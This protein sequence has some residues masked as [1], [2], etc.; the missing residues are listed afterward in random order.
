MHIPV[1]RSWRT[2][3]QKMKKTLLL[4]VAAGLLASC[5]K[6]HP[7]PKWEDEFGICLQNFDYQYEK[8]LTKGDISKH[9]TIDEGSYELKISPTK[10]QY[11][12]ATYSWKSDRP[13]R[14]ME[15]LGVILP[16]PDPNM[17]ELTQLH[18]YDAKELELYSQESII[19]LFEIGYRAL[20]E[21]E[22]KKIRENLAREF[23]DDPAKLEQANKLLDARLTSDYKHV[24]QLGS[25]AYWKWNQQYGLELNVLAGTVSF[26][27][28]TRFSAD[29]ETTLPITIALAR[30]ILAKCN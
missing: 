19:N 18:F 22:V 13:D 29:A 9:I 2:Q 16:W 27:L 26:S 11:G 4:F 23:A 24:D 14:E 17:A 21:A 12:D 6:D 15:L 3:R 30:E 5:S 8:I 7:G 25:S 20:T 1:G 10:G 28:R